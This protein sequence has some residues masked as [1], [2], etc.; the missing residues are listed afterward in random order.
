MLHANLAY[1]NISQL[2]TQPHTSSLVLHTN[3]AYLNISQLLTQPHTSSLVLHANLAY[4]RRILYHV[5]SQ[6][7]FK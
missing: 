6:Y 7:M 3:L 1:L 4:F 5:V 2:L